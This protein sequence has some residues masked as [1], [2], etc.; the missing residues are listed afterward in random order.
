MACRKAHGKEN[1]VKGLGP[2]TTILARVFLKFLLQFYTTFAAGQMD[3]MIVFC[4][5]SCFPR[6]CKYFEE[7]CVSRGTVGAI[8]HAWTTS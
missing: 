2:V 6:Q 1:N 8:S 3:G 7:I 5:F 4:L